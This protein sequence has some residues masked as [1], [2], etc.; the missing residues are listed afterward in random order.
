VAWGLGERKVIFR[1]GEASHTRWRFPALPLIRYGGSTMPPGPR[2]TFYPRE[3]GATA[4]L[5]TPFVAAAVLARSFRWQ[6]VA[7]LG[8]IAAAYAMKE[9]LV[10]L[11]RRRGQWLGQ[12]FGTWPAELRAA[13]TW[14]V[15]E[16][17]IAGV[18]A[19]ALLLTGPWMDYAAIFAGAAGFFGFAFWI[20][21]RNRQRNPLF[22]V[23]CAIALTSTSLVAAL[24]ATGRFP[25]WCWPLWLL[26]AA[27]ATG[28]IFTVH[29]RLDAMLAL[30]K[31][32]QGAPAEVSTARRSAIIAC[33][34]M[35][36][37]S[38]AAVVVHRPIVG[39]GL[40]FAACGYAWDLR[41]QRD[42]A[43][44]KTPLTRVGQRSLALSLVYG[45]MIIL[46]LM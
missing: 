34:A 24:S 26:L 31:T 5:L 3:H 39:A 13:A 35:V 11:G 16:A 29:A 27:Q 19:L 6:E 9:P 28:G 30:R 41:R 45:V 20:N 42:A 14:L 22:Q 37:G 44:L 7:G 12:A 32:A 4:M 38:V 40:L 46:G 43:E 21:L 15:A 8:A 18:S 36:L 25:G 33:V 23:A 10:V 1:A 2:T 17:P